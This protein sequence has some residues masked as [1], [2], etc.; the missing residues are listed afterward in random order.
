MI[1]RA[2]AYE[3]K[4]EPIKLAQLSCS[5]MEIFLKEI[6]LCIQIL[7]SG[8]KKNAYKNS[9]FSTTGLFIGLSM[10]LSLL[11]KYAYLEPDDGN[12]VIPIEIILFGGSG[13]SGIKHKVFF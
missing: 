10:L 6:N 1:Q 8:Y 13:I 3:R 5:Q 11:G 9:L 4:E 7:T 2:A 12:S